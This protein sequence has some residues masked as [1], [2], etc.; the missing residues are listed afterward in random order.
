MWFAGLVCL[1][2]C[3]CVWYS[4]MRHFVFFLLSHPSSSFLLPL[5]SN[6]NSEFL[7]SDFRFY[8]LLFPHVS[9]LLPLASYLLPLS[10]FRVPVFRFPLRVYPCLLPLASCLVPVAQPRIPNACFPVSDLLLR[11][12]SC[13]FPNSQFMFSGFPCPRSCS[14]FLLALLE[15]R[16]IVFRFRFPLSAVLFTLFLLSFPPVFPFCCFSAFLSS[17]LPCA[18]TRQHKSSTLI[19]LVLYV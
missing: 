12:S 8:S 14:P 17:L 4:L 10:E 1:F 19:T 5:A 7:F 6:P 15:C 2:A 13:L 11:I 9:R 3:F 16:I 18:C